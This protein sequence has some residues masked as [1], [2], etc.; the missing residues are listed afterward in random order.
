MSR[1]PTASLIA[2]GNELLNGEVRDSNLFNL[3]RN[4]TLLGFKVEQV[5]MVRDNVQRIATL[6]C[7][8][9]EQ[10]PDVLIVTGGLGPTADDLTLEAVAQAQEVPLAAD[11]T[12]RAM[13]EQHYDRLIA[14]GYLHK[15]G[16]ESARSKMATLPEGAR[17]LPNPIGTAPGVEL[18]HQNTYIYC[19]P[20]VPAELEAIFS[21]TLAPELRQRFENGSWVEASV[22]VRCEDE[23]NVAS[24]LHQVAQRHPET[25][26]KSLARPFP[27]ANDAHLRIII[28]ARAAE[29]AIARS[30]VTDAKA[31][32]QDALKS[33]HIQ[34]IQ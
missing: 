6:L 21:A 30:R 12:A 31:D 22:T 24:V 33:A 29:D 25:Y 3:L 18:T 32:L 26:I 28:A 13:V 4:L 17:P 15:R 8:L 34:I 27:E 9:L 20:G 23:A 7:T 19:L 11:P 1:T 14:Q 5:A 10:E 2:V 16:P